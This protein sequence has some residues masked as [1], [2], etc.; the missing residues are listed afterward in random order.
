MDRIYEQN[1]HI[2]VP[3]KL[4]KYSSAIG[5]KCETARK[6]AL[7]SARKEIVILVFHHLELGINRCQPCL[8]CFHCFLQLVLDLPHG[9][10][11]LLTTSGLQ[12]RR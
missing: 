10:F 12:S 5:M 7:N 11:L 4:Y 8:G 9:L 1:L 3:I 2:D 6:T